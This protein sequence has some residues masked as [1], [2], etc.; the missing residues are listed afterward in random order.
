VQ[1]IARRDFPVIQGAVMIIAGIYV[2]VNLLVDIL[3]VYIDPR[4]RYGSK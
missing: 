4:V 2:L 3:Y 1:S